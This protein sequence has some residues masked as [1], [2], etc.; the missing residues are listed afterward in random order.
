MTPATGSDPRASINPNYWT[1]NETAIVQVEKRSDR[2]V[3]FASV[4]I[5]KVYCGL[6]CLPTAPHLIHCHVEGGGR[7]PH[8]CF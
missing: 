8:R 1:V 2:A 4:L 6:A 5:E 7:L 3:L